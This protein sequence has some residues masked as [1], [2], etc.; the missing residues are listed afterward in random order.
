MTRDLRI[1]AM[2]L[3]GSLALAGGVFAQATLPAPNALGFYFDNEAGNNNLALG[4]ASSSVDAYLI[5]TEATVAE[6]TGWEV[7][8]TITAGTE[9]V[10]HS[11]P[12]GTTLTQAGPEDWVAVLATPMPGNP[13]TKLAGFTLA[14]DAAA[15]THIYL[16]NVDNPS[17]PGALPGIQAD[18]GWSA[19]PVASGDPDTPVAGINSSTPT[20]DHSWGE[21]KALYR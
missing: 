3:V 21:I 7:K 5:F 9:I 1:A 8:I 10:G 15:N 19:L 6:I 11:L 18:G 16:G 2:A 17:A 14:T 13:L 12:V 4:S 20:T